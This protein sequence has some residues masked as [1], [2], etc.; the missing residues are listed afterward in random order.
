MGANHSE[1][2]RR[3]Y[4]AELDI[5]EKRAMQIYIHR[6]NNYH[7]AFHGDYHVYLYNIQAQYELDCIPDRLKSGRR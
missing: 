7:Y 3:K 5:L 6:V 4:Y 1:E 2:Q